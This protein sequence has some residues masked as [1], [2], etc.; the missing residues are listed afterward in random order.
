MK[1]PFV[2]APSS[3]RTRITKSRVETRAGEN[4]IWFSTLGLLAACAQSAETTVAE[5]PATGA[6]NTDIVPDIESD[7]TPEGVPEPKPEAAPEPKPEAAPEPKPEGPPPDLTLVND[8]PEAVENYDEAHHLGGRLGNVDTEV[9]IDFALESLFSNEEGLDVST[10]DPSTIK[11]LS[12][13]TGAGWHSN[14]GTLHVPQGTSGK[15]VVSA[16][17]VATGEERLFAFDFAEPDSPDT[18]DDSSEDGLLPPSFLTEA[19]EDDDVSQEFLDSLTDKQIEA[20][21]SGDY[22]I[23]DF[24]LSLTPSQMRLLLPGE[25]IISEELGEVTTMDF[26][27]LSDESLELLLVLAFHD[28][29]EAEFPLSPEEARD[30]L[31]DL[32]DTMSVNGEGFLEAIADDEL[33]ISSLFEQMRRQTSRKPRGTA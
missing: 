2:V 13:P 23:E 6:G 29:D 32:F 4:L 28:E 20:I 18:D 10:I 17:D 5:A 8:D 31:F 25:E 26:S 33:L 11:V 16:L 24:M 1:H 30:F 22:T 9:K 14:T 27:A 19:F 15:V 7:L 12:A 21:E 3:P